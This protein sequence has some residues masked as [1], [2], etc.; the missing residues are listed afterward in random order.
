MCRGSCSFVTIIQI[1]LMALITI[2][3]VGKEM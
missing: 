1:M 3:S 2:I